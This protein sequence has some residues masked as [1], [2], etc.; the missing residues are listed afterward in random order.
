MSLRTRLLW[1]VDPAGVSSG[2]IVLATAL[3]ERDAS[4]I[5]HADHVRSHSP[6]AHSLQP[7]G[8]WPG[9]SLPILPS[10]LPLPACLGACHRIRSPKKEPVMFNEYAHKR[11]FQLEQ[12][13]MVQELE[14]K[15][16]V[17]E[18]RRSLRQKSALARVLALL[19]PREARANRARRTDRV[20]QPDRAG[21]ADRVVQ[22]DRSVQAERSLPETV[23]SK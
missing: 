21:H 11:L 18:S 4:L 6:I 12:Q 3:R 22:A 1:N 15:R 14:Q 19:V 23:L 10:R 8:T 5:G 7:R 9:V 2:E 16:K 20:G 17:L 13:R